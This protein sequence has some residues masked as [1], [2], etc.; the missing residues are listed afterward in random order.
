MLHGRF[1]GCKRHAGSSL[2]VGHE[3]GPSLTESVTPHGDITALQPAAGLVGRILGFLCQLALASHALF[4]ILPRMVEIAHIDGDAQQTAHSKACCSLCP[5]A[6]CMLLDGIGQI[7]QQHE[8]H[9]KEEVIGHLH[10]IAQY[11]QGCEQGCDDDARQITPFI[12]Q[13]HTGYGGR[14]KTQ[15]KQFPYMTRSDNDEI[16]TA[17]GPQHSAQ[18]SHPHTEIKCTQ[19]DIEAQQHHEHI[20]SHSRKAQLIHLLKHGKHIGAVIAG[21]H[22]IGRHTTKEAVGPACALTMM[23]LTIMIH[24]HT[25]SCRSTMVMSRQ[26]QTIPDG[27][28][29]IRH[30][31]GHKED[32]GQHV[33]QNSSNLNHIQSVCFRFFVLSSLVLFRKTVGGSLSN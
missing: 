14:Y 15:R 29:E 4:T 26:Y 30:A 23:R 22:L 3:Q 8:S 20:G 12:A 1:A 2:G 19:Q 16:I 9:D 11:L 32:D 7:S 31:D 28:E 6:Q 18:G 13:Y 21:T 24:L 5:P 33:G 27:R 25:T 10:M 17:E